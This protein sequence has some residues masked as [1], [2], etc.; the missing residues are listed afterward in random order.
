MRWVVSALVVVL[1]AAGVGGYFLYQRYSAA[2]PE[3]A[4]GSYVG[5]YTDS[6]TNRAIPWGVARGE[7]DATLAVFVSDIRIPAQ[8]AATHDPTGK[9]RLPLVVGTAESRLRF[10]GKGNSPTEY[11]GEYT[12]PISGE[13]GTW[14]L[15]RIQLDDMSP[16]QQDNLTRWFALWQELEKI[17]S[18]IQESQQ[19]VDTR[20]AAVDNLHAYVTDGS[21]LRKTA[22]QRLGRA[23][24]EIEAARG[25]LSDRQQQLDRAI[26]DFDLSQRISPQGKLVYLSRQTIQRESRWV[27]LTLKLLAPETSPGF[28]QALDKAERVR[29]LKRKIAEEREAALKQGEQER[30]K[31]SASETQAEEE[32]YGQLQ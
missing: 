4:S 12:N 9:T 29:S 7:E 22:D 1:V 16:A 21:A 31:G 24:S 11:S 28:Q 27:E 25:D 15:R 10:T 20:Q 3:L 2:F 13:R 32:F 6:Q 30:Y 8:R 5:L 17:E 19:T 14:T 26:R 18:E 23:D